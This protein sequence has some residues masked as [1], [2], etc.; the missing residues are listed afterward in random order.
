MVVD[1]MVT[2]PR[3]SLIENVEFDGALYLNFFFTEDTL[4]CDPRKNLI[5]PYVQCS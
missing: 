1:A 5:R 3:R 2:M 4:F